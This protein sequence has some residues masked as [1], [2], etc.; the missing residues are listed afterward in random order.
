MKF[1]FEDAI[2]IPL[3]PEDNKRLNLAFSI[4]YEFM[5]EKDLSVL[6]PKK[7]PLVITYLGELV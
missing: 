5:Y 2:G 4:I 6:M 1:E 7:V 3:S